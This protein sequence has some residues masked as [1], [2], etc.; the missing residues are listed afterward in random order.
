MIGYATITFS[1][2][3]DGQ[4]IFTL[5]IDHQD[6]DPKPP[7]NWLLPKAIFWNSIWS[8]WNRD[9]ISFPVN[10]LWQ[11][12]YLILMYRKFWQLEPLIRCVL[13]LKLKLSV[14]GSILPQALMHTFHQA[15][16]FNWIEMLWLLAYLL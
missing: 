3:P 2:D 1:Y 6:D 14:V 7:W 10:L 15:E 12:S 11:L 8:T 16:L 5:I 9:K 4:F 13:T